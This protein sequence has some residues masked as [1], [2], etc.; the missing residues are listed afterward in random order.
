MN[1]KENSYFYSKALRQGVRETF[2]RILIV[3]FVAFNLMSTDKVFSLI[4]NMNIFSC[5]LIWFTCLM[6]RSIEQIF[7]CIYSVD[8]AI[9]FMS[10]VSKIEP[11]TIN[12]QSSLEVQF[13]NATKLRVP[14]WRHVF[15]N[16]YFIE[17]HS[18][19]A[20]FSTCA[21]TLAWKINSYKKYSESTLR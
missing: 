12:D 2:Q 20:K 4:I 11:S 9:Y 13:S 1:T 7:S 14:H 15:D 5:M 17:C 21:N 18:N 19:L 16:F 8:A 6:N 10:L 3:L